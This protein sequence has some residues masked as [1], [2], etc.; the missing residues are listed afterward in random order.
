[1]FANHAFPLMDK[2]RV[3][4]ALVKD[5]EPITYL[6]ENSP[7][8]HIIMREK[9]WEGEYLLFAKTNALPAASPTCAPPAKP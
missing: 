7:A 5:D 3:D 6:L 4:H 2:Y 9:A 1:M 8:W